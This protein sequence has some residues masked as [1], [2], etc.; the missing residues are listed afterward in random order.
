MF[1][2]S[3][4]FLVHPPTFLHVSTSPSRIFAT[5]AII[6]NGCTLAQPIQASPRL[7]PE[8]GF[9]SLR[10]RGLGGYGLGHALWRWQVN[11]AAPYLASI[12]DSM[13]SQGYATVGLW[14]QVKVTSVGT[15]MVL[16]TGSRGLQM[17][18]GDE[19]RWRG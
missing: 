14:V 17:Q 16:V 18:G 11:G 5:L 4:N 8:S 7:T 6:N 3:Y 1:T 12:I 13:A 9:T 15:H 2:I 19:M 10:S